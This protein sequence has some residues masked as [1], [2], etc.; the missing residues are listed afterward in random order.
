MDK[1]KTKSSGGLT[2][3]RSMRVPGVCHTGTCSMPNITEHQHW[4]QMSRLRQIEAL[5]HASR[6]REATLE[7][8]ALKRQRQ[9][10]GRDGGWLWDGSHIC[11]HLT[12]WFPFLWLKFV[13]IVF[14]ISIVFP[15]RFKQ[16]TSC[17][18]VDIFK[19]LG[20]QLGLHKFGHMYYCHIDILRLYI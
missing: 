4:M 6:P 2:V 19:T 7:E 10:E 13:F 17:N 20:K 16:R 14:H 3:C 5:E 12:T 9:D 15:T 8:P 11:Q 1:M 18:S